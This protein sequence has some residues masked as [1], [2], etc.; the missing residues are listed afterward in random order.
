MLQRIYGTAWPSQVELD[1]YLELLAE[2]ENATT[3]D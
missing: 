1:S 2:A 3:G